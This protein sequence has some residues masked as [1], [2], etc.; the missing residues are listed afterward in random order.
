MFF[1]KKKPKY[2]FYLIDDDEEL[3]TIRLEA[4]RPI[5]LGIL[6][7]VE[8]GVY[9]SDRSKSKNNDGYFLTAPTWP[10]DGLI[11]EQFRLGTADL[12][13]VGIRLGFIHITA[14]VVGRAVLFLCLVLAAIIFQAHAYCRARLCRR[15]CAGL[16]GVIRG[17]VVGTARVAGDWAEYAI[18]LD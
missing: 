7:Q 3:T 16:S 5:E 10:D 11:P 15:V 6:T 8:F 18:A 2:T 9:Y 12:S 13:G 17:M 1:G 4:A 14:N